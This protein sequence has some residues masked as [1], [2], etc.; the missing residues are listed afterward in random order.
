MTEAARSCRIQVIEVGIPAVVH[1]YRD[2]DEVHPPPDLVLL[3]RRA[4]T[5][6]PSRIQG[7]LTSHP[8]NPATSPFRPP[9]LMVS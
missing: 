3:F 6:W 4:P 9:L 8:A 2:D 1:Y 5:L 7:R